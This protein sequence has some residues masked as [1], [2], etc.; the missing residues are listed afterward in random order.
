MASPYPFSGA[1]RTRFFAHMSDDVAAL[2]IFVG[3]IS[4]FEDVHVD[5]LWEV[6]LQFG[7]QFAPSVSN[8]VSQVKCGHLG[9]SS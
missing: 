9:F 4:D 6:S 5:A 1:S 3:R 8:E 7:F 2:L